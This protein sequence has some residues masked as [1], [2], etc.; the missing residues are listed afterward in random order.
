MDF[1]KG[2]KP[3]GKR[4]RIRVTRGGNTYTKTI[5]CDPYSKT[6]VTHALRVRDELISRLTL[7]LHVEPDEVSTNIL[8]RDAAQNYLNQIDV[9]YSTARTYQKILNRYWLPVF[10]NRIVSDIKP[11]MV[12]SAVKQ[13]PV[14]RKTQRNVLGPLRGVFDWCIQNDY[15]IANPCTG[16][17]I[18]KHSKPLHDPF[19]AEEKDKIL[20]TIA[21]RY[22]TSHQRLVY[23]TMLFET[24]LRPSEALALHWPDYDGE[25]IHI[26]KSIVMSKHKPCTKNHE[27][28]KVYVNKRLK[29]IL[30]NHT[31]RFKHE[32]IFVHSKGGPYLNASRLDEHWRNILTR[33]K[34]RYR[35]PYN[36]RHS[37]ASIGLSAGL[38]PA[39]LASQLGHTLEVF[40]R[41]YASWINDDRNTEQ[42]K[43][44]DSM[45][46]S[47]PKRK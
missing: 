47:C 16:I 29:P 41:T 36:C 26:T 17:R 6:G 25:F 1:P 11:A 15:V 12:N 30:S 24:G 42:Y 8:F 34:V 32:F 31:T 14:S 7:G 40:Y 44:M 10:G 45:N 9:E 3:H 37:Y 13:L 27:N 22:G 20:S 23:C 35:R 46:Q 39:F 19:S 21:K 4:L 33:A 18:R 43:K 28:R 5:E 2:I 38:E